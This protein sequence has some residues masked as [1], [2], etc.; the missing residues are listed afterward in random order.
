M[1]FIDEVHEP[2]TFYGVERPEVDSRIIPTTWRE[3]GARR[4]LHAHR[5]YGLRRP[6][7]EAFEWPMAMKNGHPSPRGQGFS[8]SGRC[9]AVLPISS[10]RPER[11]S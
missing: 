1:G 8:I 4:P 11:R 9:R 7:P 10:C 3:L 6:V 5:P 2:P